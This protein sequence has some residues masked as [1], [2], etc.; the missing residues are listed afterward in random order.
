MFL[1]VKYKINNPLIINRIKIKRNL[2]VLKKLLKGVN[3]I[4]INPVKLLIK[5]R[6]YLKIFS[7]KLFI[8][9]YNLLKYLIF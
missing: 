4:T 1:I 3:I 2:E 6:G 7:Q 8:K 9:N 5:K